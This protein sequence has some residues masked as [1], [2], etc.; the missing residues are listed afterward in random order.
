MIAVHL[1]CKL[2]ERAEGACGN[3]DAAA[4][5]LH[6]YEVYLLAALGR[7]VGV[8]AGVGV[9]GHFTGQNVNA[10]HKAEVIRMGEA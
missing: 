10:G 5:Q 9:I 7:D 2:F 6:L 4:I 8:A 3:T 1:F